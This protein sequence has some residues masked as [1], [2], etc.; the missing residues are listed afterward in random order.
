MARTPEHNAIRRRRAFAGVVVTVGAI[1]LA[2]AS[3]ALPGARTGC[4]E[5][6]HERLFFGLDGP[7][8]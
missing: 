7:E 5:H 4:S 2:V 8:K 1:V 6:V 3:A